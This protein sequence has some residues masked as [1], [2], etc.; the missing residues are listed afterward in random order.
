MIAEVFPEAYDV[1]GTKVLRPD[2]R[3]KGL[4]STLPMGRYVSQPV[5]VKCESIGDIRRFLC[6]CKYVSDEEQFGKKDYWQAP[7]EFE[8]TMKG[9]C[10]CFALWTRRQFLAL[11]FNARFVTG[12]SGRYGTGHAWVQFSKEGKNFLVEPG[13][14]RIGYSLPRLNTLQY[15]PRFS[16]AWDGTTM[17]FY[18]HKDR[19]GHPSLLQMIKLVPAWLIFWVWIWTML[20]VL[21]PFRFYRRMRSK[22]RKLPFQ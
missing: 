9:D 2:L 22:V 3:R 13:M 15:H 8:K 7:E 4:H 1:Q 5:T 14:A 17:S 19:G 12:R 6:D 21:F 18:E 11:G 20:L 10:D 16:V